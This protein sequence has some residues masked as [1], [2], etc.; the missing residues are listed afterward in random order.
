MPT[1]NFNAEYFPDYEIL[2]KLG[3]SNA[4]VFKARHRATGE[5][6][7]IKHFPFNIDEGTLRRFRRESELMTS[8]NHPNIVAIRDYYFEGELPYLV[9]EWVEGGDLRGQLDAQGHLPVPDVL[10]LGLQVGEA[11][12]VIHEAGIIHRDIKPENILCRQLQSGEQQY[13]LTDFGVSRLKG[14]GRSTGLTSMTYEYASP[15]CFYDE[16]NLT[17]ASDYYALGV[18]LFE[19]LTRQVPYSLGSRGI[20]AL[21]DSV[22]YQP[23]PALELPGGSWLPPSLEKLVTGLLEKQPSNRLADAML[24]KRS[25]KRADLE[26]EEGA[27][28]APPHE[29]L[30]DKKVPV[31]IVTVE[32]EVGMTIGSELENADNQNIGEEDNSQ[33]AENYS[34]KF[35]A[36]LVGLMVLGFVVV[37]VASSMY[38]NNDPLPLD[39]SLSDTLVMEEEMDTMAVMADDTENELLSPISKP[40]NSA[41]EGSDLDT[42]MMDTLALDLDEVEE[43]VFTV[44]EQNPEFPGGSLGMY[45]FLA[46]NLR[47]PRD[48]RRANVSGKVFLAFVVNTDGS[49]QDVQVLKGLGFGCDEEAMRL[50]NAMPKW[51]PGRQ[52][53]RAVRVKYNLPISFQLE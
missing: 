28:A 42:M 51:K 34:T 27:D 8:L 50:A 45:G 2:G 30:A 11:L 15:E 6:V 5:V 36:S 41:F 20:G 26:W 40:T 38:Q 1:V 33:K 52:S 24:L 43:Q 12:R 39:A 47:Y 37:W 9:M 4:R 19:S 18:V 22:K 14:Q 46:R 10:R 31:P 13:L 29:P 44:V 32:K 48:A 35:V 21:M 7:A 16:E 17:E 3:H 25:L 53:G 23:L 49:I